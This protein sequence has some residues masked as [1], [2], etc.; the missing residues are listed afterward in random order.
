[1][2]RSTGMAAVAAETGFASRQPR[3]PATASKPGQGEGG[4]NSMSIIGRARRSIR[5]PFRAKPDDRVA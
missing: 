3:C 4:G 5:W 2:T 1:M